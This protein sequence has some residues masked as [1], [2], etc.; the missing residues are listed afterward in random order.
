MY[1]VRA[2]APPLRV[3][4]LYRLS[5]V[6]LAA[7]AALVAYWGFTPSSAAVDSPLKIDINAREVED[8]GVR[9]VTLARLSGAN[10]DDAATSL[11]ISTNDP[12]RSDTDTL[13]PPDR[14]AAATLRVNAELTGVSYPVTVF[15]MSQSTGSLKQV[16]LESNPGSVTVFDLLPGIAVV[17]YY[18][19]SCELTVSG[20]MTSDSMAL[21][22]PHDVT[23]VLKP[24]LNEVAL[25]GSVLGTLRG[26]V[27]DTLGESV[28]NGSVQ[29]WSADLH[30][31]TKG[32]VIA[33]CRNGQ[34]EV[35]VAPGEWYASLFRFNRP[36][37][38][39][40]PSGSTTVRSASLAVMNL[41][42]DVGS[43]TIS[44]RVIDD[45]GDPFGNLPV[46]LERATV[47]SGTDGRPRCDALSA[48]G[49]QCRSGKDGS[50]AFNCLVPGYY[51]ITAEL[52]GI[53]LLAGTGELVPAVGAP[54][55]LIEII[56]TDVQ[57]VALL[58]ARAPLVTIK[59]K[60]HFNVGRE[61]NWTAQHAAVRTWSSAIPGTKRADHTRS[62]QSNGHFE[63]L[64]R[65]S[66]PDLTMSVE[67]FGIYKTYTVYRA[68]L[69]VPAVPVEIHFP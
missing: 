16:R 7:L 46:Y 62:I 5:F 41:S 61:Q 60:I 23:V 52:G 53:S 31:M 3:K 29:L 58:A 26:T 66:V 65:K 54:V 56:D 28:L 37:G 25:V 43:Y 36:C 64:V 20:P 1:S 69:G 38:S 35:N 10:G 47:S 9:S 40:V 48:A 19:S 32:F 44:G 24:G 12:Q 51:C 45:Q 33:P 6:F 59:G 15:V 21:M 50:F 22:S 17:G 13:E 49:H 4:L 55:P 18:D 30:N 11:A 34:Y 42:L 39:S 14:A 57:E 2:T 27:T 68:D 8:E 63:F 67:I